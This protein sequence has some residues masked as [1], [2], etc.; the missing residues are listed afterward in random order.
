MFLRASVVLGVV[1]ALGESACGRAASKRDAVSVGSCA[2]KSAL[3]L[4]LVGLPFAG[5][6][7]AFEPLTQALVHVTSGHTEPSHGN[8]MTVHAPMMRGVA[9]T[10]TGSGVELAFEYHGPSRETAAFASGEVRRQ[11]GIKL[12]AANTCNVIYAMWYADGP[13]NIHVAVKHNEGKTREKE[14]G[15]SGYI[16]VFATTSTNVAALAAG[17]SHVMR[18]EIEGDRLI[19]TVDGAIAWRGELPPEVRL[20]SGPAGLRSDNVDFDFELRVPRASI[21]D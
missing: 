11:I 2:S 13:S 20:Q 18:A 8:W 21:G 19:V 7:H 3:S 17:S 6:A 14:C 1:F 5:A 10:T 15:D 4:P 16:P 12:R 9:M